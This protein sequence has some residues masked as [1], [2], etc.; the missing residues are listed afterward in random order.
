MM[1]RLNDPSTPPGGTARTTSP[2]TAAAAAEGRAPR[3]RPGGRF[4]AVL[5]LAGAATHCGNVST[6]PSRLAACESL[7]DR[8]EAP[9][10]TAPTLDVGECTAQ[11][12]AVA[13]DA[14]CLDTIE[15]AR[16]DEAIASP[17]TLCQ[18]RCEQPDT[19]TCAGPQVRL[20]TATGR[21]L[22][23]DCASVCGDIPG[24][25]NA[26][27]T[28]LAGGSATDLCDCG[29]SADLPVTN[30]PPDPPPCDECEL[31]PEIEIE[32]WVNSFDIYATGELWPFGK[33]RLVFKINQLP[34]WLP[35]YEI[36]MRAVR[37]CIG[38]GTRTFGPSAEG[39][40][41]YGA[42]S[43]DVDLDYGSQLC[44]GSVYEARVRM[45]TRTAG[46]TPAST[47]SRWRQTTATFP[48]LVIK[49]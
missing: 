36:E 15:N 4:L 24:H 32:P 9:D 20:C 5:L 22:T 49:H 10:A 11:L 8:C 17:P 30:Y 40:T 1:A 21:E 18:P 39:L 14:S 28:P 25:E 45:G 6:P 37:G 34:H 23:A 19:A 35:L 41:T 43:L 7:A 29:S 26:I 13:A 44:A 3:L 48:G 46:W 31:E 2:A 38:F 47:W 16:C 42:I 33:A 27:C 12:D